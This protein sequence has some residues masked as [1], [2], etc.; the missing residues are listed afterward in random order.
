MLG[1]FSCLYFHRTSRQKV[2][3]EVSA[4]WR[5]CGSTQNR[6]LLIKEPSRTLFEHLYTEKCFYIFTYPGAFSGVVVFMVCVLNFISVSEGQPFPG[7][8]LW[9]GQRHPT[10]EPL[11]AEE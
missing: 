11:S 6:Y 1:R 4:S 8:L 5:H 7:D 3:L 10:R 2:Q 9:H